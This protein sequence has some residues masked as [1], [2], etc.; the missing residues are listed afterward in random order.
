MGNNEDFKKSAIQ[1][2][3]ELDS[4]SKEISEYIDIFSGKHESEAAKV[5]EALF[6]AFELLA[7]KK[8]EDLFKDDIEKLK[9]PY[10]LIG[11]DPKKRISLDSSFSPDTKTALI[12]ILDAIG[13]VGSSAKYKKDAIER[14]RDLKGLLLLLNGAQKEYDSEEH[15]RSEQRAK[16]FVNHLGITSGKRKSKINKERL[17]WEYLELIYKKVD[18]N[19]PSPGPSIKHEALEFLASKYGLASADSLLEQLR[20]YIREKKKIEKENED[21]EIEGLRCIFDGIRL[22]GKKRSE[23]SS[24]QLQVHDQEWEK[25]KIERKKKDFIS[26]RY[27]GILPGRNLYK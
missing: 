7:N 9:E 17:Y 10:H 6:T 16:A 12:G 5:S 2:W 23:M 26:N 4:K 19:T 8:M 3:D 11:W 24:K 25:F 15:T 14:K 1:L 13:I 20:R 18:C 21:E 22:N 27:K